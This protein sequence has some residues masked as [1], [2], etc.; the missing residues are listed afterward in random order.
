MSAGAFVTGWAGY[1]ALFPALSE[2]LDVT[3]P[4]VDADED[5]LPDRLPG[6]D[7]LLAWSTG[8]HMV[9]KHRETVFPR[10]RR[11]VLAAPFLAFYD[12]VP[13]DT[14][15]AMLEAV[16][17]EGPMRTVRAFY[18]NCGLRGTLPEVPQADAEALA[19]G[20]D[21]LLGSRV[22]MVPGE[23]G[24]RVRILHGAGDRIVPMDASAVV[25]GLLNGSWRSIIDAGHWVPEETLLDVLHEET[26]RDAFRPR[27]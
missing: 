19:R 27:R 23:D 8:A 18:R 9:L 3:V 14:V 10:Y 15:R 16:R 17:A 4:F 7:V 1:A 5:A 21:Y 20:L 24:S 2:L 22:C 13:R 26:G 11:V 25:A 6:G 12:H